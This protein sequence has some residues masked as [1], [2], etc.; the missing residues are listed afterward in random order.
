MSRWPFLCNLSSSDCV[1]E[2]ISSCLPTGSGRRTRDG[3]DS[4]ASGNDRSLKLSESLRLAL[5]ASLRRADASA[6][7]TPIAAAATCR[8][9]NA[10]TSGGVVRR[11]RDASESREVGSLNSGPTSCVTVSD[12]PA[13]SAWPQLAGGNLPGVCGRGLGTGTVRLRFSGFGGGRRSGGVDIGHSPSR[14]S[15]RQVTALGVRQRGLRL[16]HHGRCKS[17]C[18]LLKLERYAVT[19]TKNA[20]FP[21]YLP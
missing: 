16:L 15:G 13:L 14:S 9:P 5:E 19:T 17:Q 3:E 2:S 18:T 1:N 10:S 21:S 11:R 6:G 12:S 7:V 4:A 20:M 8:G